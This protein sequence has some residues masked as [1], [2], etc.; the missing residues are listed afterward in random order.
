MA[1]KK[2]GGGSMFDFGAVVHRRRGVKKMAKSE[3]I[4]DT[5][6]HLKEEIGFLHQ[7]IELLEEQVASEQEQKYDAYRRLADTVETMID[8]AMKKLIKAQ[9][10]RKL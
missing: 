7:K 9:K 4:N 1:A 6:L 2:G 3:D 5:V 10:K 8:P